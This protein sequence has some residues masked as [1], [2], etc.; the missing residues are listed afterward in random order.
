MF[1]NNSQAINLT[2]FTKKSHI[3]HIDF[4]DSLWALCLARA[5]LVC[6]LL[7]LFIG[8]VKLLELLMIST[9]QIINKKKCIK[10]NKVVANFTLIAFSLNAF[11]LLYPTVEIVNS[12]FQA[13]TSGPLLIIV[14]FKQKKISV[15]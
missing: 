12:H 9:E 14:K 1:S 8:I 13:F 15:G 2:L 10:W 6:L 11:E 7:F 3:F 4:D 5:F